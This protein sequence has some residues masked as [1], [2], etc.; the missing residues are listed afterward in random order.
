MPQA[1]PKGILHALAVRSSEG[2]L[3][4]LRRSPEGVDLC[5]ND[6]LGL[7]QRSDF[8]LGFAEWWEASSHR[9]GAT[10]SRLVSG[11]FDELEDLECFLAQVH[12]AECALL[13]SSGFEANSALLSALGGRSDTILYDEQVHASMRDGVRLSVARAY[14]FK[15]ND[16]EH[17]QQRISRAHER[18]PGDVYVAVES[19]YSMDGDIA[20]LAAL[21]ELCSRSGAYLIV[22]E[23]HATGLFGEHGTGLV[24]HLKLEDSIFARVHTFGKALGFR[25]ACVVGS[26]SL[27]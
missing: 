1:P 19:V 24:Q 11:N 20:P 22:D 14:S 12:Q 21:S 5:S 23:A 4:S 27:R 6:Y 18:S 26:E 8:L 25:G 9:M 7:A 17:L 2:G 3:R 10:G 13:F 15:H 16:T